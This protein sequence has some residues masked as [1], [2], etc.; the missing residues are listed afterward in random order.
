MTRTN[1][2]GQPIGE[3][4]DWESAPPPV[5]VVLT[6]RYVTVCGLEHEHAPALYDALCGPED[7]ALWTYRIAGMPATA[8][9]MDTVVAGLLAHPTE[10]TFAICPRGRGPEGIATLMR[11][12]PA[13]GVV[14]VG[15]IVQAGTMQRS[16]ENLRKSLG[17]S[18]AQ[19]QQLLRDNPRKILTR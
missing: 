12:D 19:I 16:A 9:A 5:P 17:L 2:H 10:V 15:G 18:D 4:V 7:A 6:G 1:E 11:V 3:A 8:A 14:E 13:N